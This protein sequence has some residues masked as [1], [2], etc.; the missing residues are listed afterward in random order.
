MWSLTHLD[1]FKY[2]FREIQEL[3]KE[4]KIYE[5]S[6]IVGTAYSLWNMNGI[7]EM[8]DWETKVQL[9]HWNYILSH[10]T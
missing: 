8:N 3:N 9:F 5:E 2:K 10:N 1:Q 6:G 4:I 7:R